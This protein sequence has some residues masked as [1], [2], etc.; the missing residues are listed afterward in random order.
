MRGMLCDVRGGRID[1]IADRN[2]FD[3]DDAALSADRQRCSGGRR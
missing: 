1:R 3:L 2:L